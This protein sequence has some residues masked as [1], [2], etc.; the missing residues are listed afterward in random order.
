MKRPRILLSA[1]YFS[2][3]KG[4]ESAVGWNVATR[5]AKHNDVTVL[6]GDVAESCPHRADLQRWQAEHIP[7][8]GLAVEYI[9]PDASISRYE[10]WHNKPGLW[11]LWYKA[12]KKW[13]RLAYQRARQLHADKPFD[14]THHL[15]VI[16][17]REPG[18]LWQL[19]IP[20]VWG[21]I[22][23]ADGIPW[24]YY[25]ALGR[26]CIPPLLRDLCN[27]MQMRL[28]GRHH[29]AA[30]AA[31]HIWSVTPADYRMVKNLWGHDTELMIET[32]CT[33]ELTAGPRVRLES[34]PIR[35]VY[36][37]LFLARKA[38]PLLFQALRHLPSKFSWHLDILGDGPCRDAWQKQ[39]IT[40]GINSGITWHGQL[41]RDH[42]LTVMR[43][44]HILV[45]P[46]LKE[47]TPHVVLEAL[48]LGMPVLCHDACG[49]GTA[50]NDTCGI[51][52]PLLNPATSIAGFAHAIECFMND[53]ELL[54]RLSTGAMAR[55]HELSW[56][57]KVNQISNVYKKI[58]SQNI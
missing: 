17:Y 3:Y 57:N 41:P 21:P 10:C 51:K 40:L 6:T 42:A 12:Y 44:G 19:P 37:G 28:P 8:P 29:R 48:A 32:G 54:T 53:S 18:Y 5:L 24:P 14:L 9:P 35:L 56:D 26:S 11:F 47:G 45:H 46:S 31:K 22:N 52:V 23:G 43:L 1:Y 49:M 16:G 50:V 33:P 4:S 25:P 27:R 58:L 7:T 38:L 20:F 36:S 13:Q 15:T 30:R 34:E 2:P 39:A 55:A